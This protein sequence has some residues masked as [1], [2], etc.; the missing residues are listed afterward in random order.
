[1]RTVVMVA[2][3]FAAMT[4]EAQSVETHGDSSPVGIAQGDGD[5]SITIRQGATSGWLRAEIRRLHERVRAAGD[6]RAAEQARRD[7]E[8]LLRL[9]VLIEERNTELG[10]VIHRVT[11]RATRQ[12]LEEALAQPVRGASVDELLTALDERTRRLLGEARVTQRQERAG[13]YGVFA[14]ILG[15]GSFVGAV[16]YHVRLRRADERLR[17]LEETSPGYLTAFSAAGDSYRRSMGLSAL[18]IGANVV[19][20]AGALHPR[21]A[22]Q[23]RWLTWLTMGAGVALGAAAVPLLTTAL[24]R[25]IAQ[26]RSR[27]RGRL[28]DRDSD[29]AASDDGRAPAP[30]GADRRPLPLR[31]DWR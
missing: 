28:V 12:A 10:D 17:L 5:V 18:S 13:R 9:G 19:A 16:V 24:F 3:L 27:A 26:R 7:L 6:E 8:Q 31:R 22:S 30:L 23:P 20:S 25:F 1:M 21:S 14:G 11:H 15:V 4:A 2:V 29:V